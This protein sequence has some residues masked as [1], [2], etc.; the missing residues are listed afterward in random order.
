MNEKSN[1]TMGDIYNKN[2]RFDESNKIHDTAIIYDNVEMGKNN[3]IGAYSVIGGDG[4][5]RGTVGEYQGK[6]KIGD[7][8][9]ISE[10]VTIQRPHDNTSTVIGDNNYIMVH[11][12]VGHDAVIGNNVEICGHTILLG[13]CKIEDNARIKVGCIIRNRIT[14]GKNAIIG[15]GSVVVKSVE[16]NITV[17]GNPAKRLDK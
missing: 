8:N 6:V 4:E 2:W 7:N 13:H 9:I 12:H 1:K 5:I 11:S 16:P 17:V 15:M 14:I 3:V 10:L